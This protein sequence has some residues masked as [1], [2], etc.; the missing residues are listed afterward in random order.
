VRVFD[1]PSETDTD[2]SES[3]PRCR[4][5]E[6]HSVLTGSASIA[7]GFVFHAIRQ[8]S[9][10]PRNVGHLL[11][12]RAKL[13]CSGVVGGI[14]LPRRRLVGRRR[15]PRRRTFAADV[16]YLTTQLDAL[17][18]DL[19]LRPSDQF[20]HPILGLATERAVWPSGSSIDPGHRT[21]L[22][23]PSIPKA[24]PFA[25]LVTLPLWSLPPT[26]IADSDA[27]HLLDTFEKGH[28]FVDSLLVRIRS[29]CH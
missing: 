28:H 23:L 3:A 16:H 7:L 24:S 10:L 5:G 11:L 4:E 13:N 2:Q 18:A 25:G 19:R 9:E 26:G 21:S 20:P 27:F 12:Q 8:M 22:R 1:R 29:Q 17:I 15:A 14:H 6:H